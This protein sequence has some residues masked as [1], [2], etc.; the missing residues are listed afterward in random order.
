LINAIAQKIINFIRSEIH[1]AP[2][3]SISID[4]TFDISRTEQVSFIIRYVDELGKI[5]ERII[6]IRDFA[7]T[8]ELALFDLFS[9]FMDKHSF[10]WMSYLVGNSFDGVTSM[11][12]RYN[13]LQT[14][15]KGICPQATFILC[16]AHRLDLIVTSCI[17]S[18]LVAVNLFGNL[19]LFGFISCSKKRVSVYREKQKLIYPKIRVRSIKKVETTW[20]MS[21]SFSLRT[22]LDA[23]EAI[24]D[25][26]D[27]IK[28]QEA[29][30]DFKTDADCNGLIGYLK[31]FEFL[32]T[33]NIFKKIFYFIEPVSRAL[34]AHDIDII[35]AMHVLKND[36]KNISALRID[37]E[38]QKMYNSTK[39]YA[40]KTITVMN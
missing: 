23:L 36:E 22:V 2:F 10:N 19:E 28:N 7:I 14:K 12:R 25:T 11:S 34:Q 29:Q 40:E 18:C 5:N 24:L 31:S 30:V 35:M 38:F 1:I 17:G 20:Y 9:E 16:H 21:Q 27:E 15:I 32:L 37:A 8:I 26:F 6:A 4:S 33:A 39:L 3:F 13:A